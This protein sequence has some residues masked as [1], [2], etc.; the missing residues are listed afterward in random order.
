VAL[1]HRLD[2]T[3]NSAYIGIRFPDSSAHG[4][5]LCRH[6]CPGCHCSDELL[7]V[8]AQVHTCV[9]H[10]RDLIVWNKEIRLLYLHSALVRRQNTRFIAYGW[11]CLLVEQT[12]VMFYHKFQSICV[13]ISVH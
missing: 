11:P 4:E 8:K 6:S 7:L 9:N 10:K 2:G 13:Y 3:E 5:C 1:G 12:N